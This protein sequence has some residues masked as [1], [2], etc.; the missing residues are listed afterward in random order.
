MKRQNNFLKTLLLAVALLAGSSMAWADNVSIPQDMGSY[1][2]IGSATGADGFASYITKNNCQVDSRLGDAGNSKYYT[3]GSTKSDTKVNI[4]V[5]ASEAGNYA[6]G[7]KSGASGCASVVTVTLTKSGSATPLYT[8]GDVTIA[9]D[10]NW[11]PNI[12][13][14]FYIEN[15]EAADYI[16]SFAVKEITSG[17]YAGNFGNFFFHKTSQL[18]WP[19]NSAYMELSDG[20]FKNARDNND[21]VINYISRTGGYI[22]D[23]LIY[24]N[25]A[26]YY[27]FNFNID[28][29]KQASKVTITITDLDTDTQEAQETKVVTG[30]GNYLQPLTTQISAGLKKV[31]FDFEDNDETADNDYLFNFRQVYF[32]SSADYEALPLT[33]TAT[34][35]LNQTGHVFSNCSYE[36]GNSN[37]GYVKNGSFADNYIV[38]NNHETAYYT[39]CA[40]IPWYKK[41]GTFTVTITDI[42]TGTEEATAT[43][44]EITGTGDVKFTIANAIT[45]GLK[46]IRFDFTKAEETDYLFNL[47]NV[48]FYKRSLN[49]GYNYTAVAATDVDVVL[50][51]SIKAGNWS[52][53]VL[54]FDIASNDITTIFGAGASVAELSSGTENT[55]NFSTTLTNSKMKANQPYAIK[56]ASDFSSKTINGVTIVSGTPTQSIANWNFVGT[57][58]ATTVPEGSYYFKSNKLYQRGAGGTTSM[59]PF[60][61]YLTYTGGG[62]S[63]AP[64]FTIDGDVTG[65]AHISA[66]GQMSLEEGAFYNLSGQRVAQPTRGLYIVNGRKVVI[67]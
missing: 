34:L 27:F 21:N 19:T 49:E 48:S 65:I 51:R 62:S 47:N 25:T 30:N 41:G 29:H 32:N 26:G 24:N 33:G 3:V 63:P 22:D 52:T 14:N 60:R 50:T 61:A 31:R 4:N 40:G 10:G 44:S 15:V 57:Y 39:L 42:A 37:I 7:F 9:D 16:L 43:S 8:S 54:P 5:T 67:K 35:N 66:D 53:I 13:H 55:L 17:S 28:S 36:E 38:Y 6:F 46:K 18:A 45:R 20:T 2:V 12:E 11:D 59:K 64:T 58:S 1:I 56:V 23:L